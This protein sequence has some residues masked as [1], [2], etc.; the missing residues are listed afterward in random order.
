VNPTWILPKRVEVGELKSSLEKDPG[1][2]DKQNIKKVKLSSGTEVFIQGAG[3]GNV[4]G[5]VKFLLEASNAIYLH[6][7]DKRYLFKNQRRDFSH[8]CIRVDG[9]IDFARWLLGR[10]GFSEEEV[11]RAFRQEVTQRGFELKRPIPLVTEYMTVDLIDEA[12]PVFYGDIYGY[13]AA[14]FERRLPAKE[15]ERWGSPRLR[16]RWVPLVDEAVVK[17]WRAAGKPAPRDYKAESK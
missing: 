15:T 4:L 3:D 5:K 12:R 10:A 16:P 6:D 11:D 17:E 13:D 8:G 1:Y 2:L 7:T 14:F 9:A